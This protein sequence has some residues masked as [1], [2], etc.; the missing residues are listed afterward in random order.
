MFG[1]GGSVSAPSADAAAISGA[2]LLLNIIS[3][4]TDRERVAADIREWAEAGKKLEA[5]RKAHDAKE[6]QLNDREAD[7][8]ARESAA[9]RREGEIAEREVQIRAEAQHVAEAKALLEQ[10]RAELRKAWAA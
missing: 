10:T 8:V 7:L 9:A 5:A 2:R 4:L 3:L 6:R 1:G